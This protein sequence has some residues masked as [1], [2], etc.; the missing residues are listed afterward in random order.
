M[1]SIFFCRVVF[2]LQTLFFSRTTYVDPI[3]HLIDIYL[4]VY[5]KWVFW[6]YLRSSKDINYST[7][8]NIL[9]RHCYPCSLQCHHNA[10]QMAC[11]A[12]LDY[13]LYDQCGMYRMY[14]EMHPS[15]TELYNQIRKKLK[16]ICWDWYYHYILIRN[17]VST[18]S[19]PLPLQSCVWRLQS[20]LAIPSSELLLLLNF[21]ARSCQTDDNATHSGHLQQNGMIM[22]L[23]GISRQDLY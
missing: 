12:T 19:R 11:M 8:Q 13:N 20:A 9:L 3:I 16:V 1:H 17:S 5:I 10:N 21:C 14:I 22:N 6:S 18:T 15:G 2:L 23:G 7:Y 4:C